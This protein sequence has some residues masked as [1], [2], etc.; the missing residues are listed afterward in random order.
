MAIVYDYACS[1]GHHPSRGG[2]CRSCSLPQASYHTASWSPKLGALTS[3]HLFIC[4]FAVRSWLLGASDCV[5]ERAR[6]RN[7]GG[8]KREERFL[9]AATALD[10]R[11]ALVS[12][13]CLHISPGCLLIIALVC[14]P[15]LSGWQ[16]CVRMW[17]WVDVCTRELFVDNKEKLTFQSPLDARDQYSL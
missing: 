2:G 5:P 15:Y 8:R 13:C 11:D 14:C 3:Y 16:L 6:E 4:G 1:R 9:Q 10:V 7:G 12:L 17:R